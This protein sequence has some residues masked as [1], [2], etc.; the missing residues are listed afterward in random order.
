M[1]QPPL[2]SAILWY[3]TILIL[4]RLLTAFCILHGPIR[5][6]TNFSFPTSDFIALKLGHTPIKL[7][8][9][10]DLLYDSFHC[11]EYSPPWTGKVSMT[12]VSEKLNV[13]WILSWAGNAKFHRESLTVQL[14]RDN[15]SL[16]HL[17]WNLNSIFLNGI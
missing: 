8:H 3:P 14:N 13:E 9:S 16:W 15:K 1:R 12:V 7:K 11:H 17:P 4:F 2:R 5:N 10:L 6:W